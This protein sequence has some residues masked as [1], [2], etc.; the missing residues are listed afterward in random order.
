MTPTNR[1]ALILEAATDLRDQYGFGLVDPNLV[2]A[3]SAHETGGFDSSLVVETNNAFGLKF[4][5]QRQTTATGHTANNYGIFNSLA[6]SV[7][8]YYMRQRNFHIPN[9]ADAQ[10]YVDATFSSGYAEDP[11]Y[12]QK[13][14][15]TYYEDGYAELPSVNVV[16]AAVPFWPILL[17]GG[18]AL[19]QAH[20]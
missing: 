16:R 12:K 14:L 5:A 2:L 17:I 13:W 20:K 15:R 8:D 4:P 7:A 11:S 3:Q 6:D 1:A 9:T 18:A 10:T 19:I